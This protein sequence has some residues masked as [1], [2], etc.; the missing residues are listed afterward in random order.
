M[1]TLKFPSGTLAGVLEDFF[2]YGHVASEIFRRN[3][4]DNEEE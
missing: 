1:W 4:W 2:L 3:G